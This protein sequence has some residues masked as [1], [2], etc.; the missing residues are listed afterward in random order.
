MAPVAGS[1]KPMSEEPMQKQPLRTSCASTIAAKSVARPWTMFPAM[2]MG[3]ETPP[4]VTVPTISG[5]PPSTP[6]MI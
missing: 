3:V 6:R 4:M 1:M 2:V 5:M